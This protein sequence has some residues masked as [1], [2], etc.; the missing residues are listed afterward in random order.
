MQR[1][2]VVTVL[3]TRSNNAAII[4][5][6]HHFRIFNQSGVGVQTTIQTSIQL[7]T[8]YSLKT[9]VTCAACITTALHIKYL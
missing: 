6:C 7:T 5:Y 9:R 1:V 4:I 8:V 2:V 3:P